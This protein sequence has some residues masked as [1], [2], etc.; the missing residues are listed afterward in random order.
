MARSQLRR[1][2]VRTM[3]SFHLYAVVLLVIF[4]HTVAADE[5]SPSEFA[6][7]VFTDLAPLLALFGEQF[8]RQFM[9]ESLTWLDHIIFAMAP[10]GI[11]TAIVGAIR[12][13]GPAWAKAFIGRA[14]ESRAAAEIEL[15]SSTSSEVCEVYNGKGVV[16]AMGTPK[17]TQFILFPPG[18]RDDDRTCGIHTLETAY[19]RKQPFLEKGEYGVKTDWETLPQQVNG[20]VIGTGI[21]SGKR[22]ALGFGADIRVHLEEES[23]NAKKSS[24]RKDKQSVLSTSPDGTM[25]PRR[26]RLWSRSKSKP[27][28][29]ED[30]VVDD[31]SRAEEKQIDEHSIDAKDTKSIHRHTFPE[32]LKGSAPNLQLNLPSYLPSHKATIGELWCA[33]VLA[34]FLQ[35]SVVVVSA[36]TSFHPRIQQTIGRPQMN[37]GFWLFIAGTLCLNLGMILCSFVIEQS[38]R[39]WAWRKTTRGLQLLG[40]EKEGD[41]SINSV[42]DSSKESQ[43]RSQVV[44]K[45]K[46]NAIAQRQQSSSKEDSNEVSRAD[47]SK[48]LPPLQLFWMQQKHTVSDQDFDPFLILGG[49]KDEILTSSRLDHEKWKTIW[50]MAIPE[51]VTRFAGNQY[52][53]LTICAS[54]FGLVGF[55]LQF[56]G[57]RGLAWPTAVSQLGAIFLLALLRA[58]IRRR[59]GESPTTISTF[60][61]HELDWLTLRLVYEQDALTAPQA[62]GDADAVKA[63]TRWKVLT[64]P[65][66]PNVCKYE[67]KKSL[68]DHPG[69]QRKHSNSHEISQFPLLMERGEMVDVQKSADLVHQRI[70][71][72]PEQD[73]KYLFQ[74]TSQVAVNVRR[75]LGELAQ[76]PGAASQEAIALAQAMSLV[77]T[78]LCP[79]QK[80]SDKIFTWSLDTVMLKVDEK[81]EARQP[82]QSKRDKSGNYQVKTPHAIPGIKPDKVTLKATGSKKGWRMRPADIDAILSL[83]MSTLARSGA[84]ANIKGRAHGKRGT[85]DDDMEDDESGNWL[86]QASSATVKYRRILGDNPPRYKPQDSARALSESDTGTGTNKRAS[87]VRTDILTRDLNWWTNDPRVTAITENTGDPQDTD[88]DML[89]IGFNGLYPRRQTVPNSD[90]PNPPKQKSQGPPTNESQVP[91]ASEISAKLEAVQDE[92]IRGKVV[93]IISDGPLAVV[94]AHHIF[95]AFMW[96]VSDEI[97]EDKIDTAAVEDAELFDGSDFQNTWNIPTLRNKRLMKLARAIVGL[98]LGPIDDVLL[99]II[100]PLSHRGILPNEAMMSVLLRKTKDHER[101]HDWPQ[102]Q[103]TYLNLLDLQMDPRGMD[104]ISYEIVVELIE[105]LF[106]ARETIDDLRGSMTLEGSEMVGNQATSLRQAVQAVSSG[107]QAHELLF[108]VASQLHW[109]YYRQRRQTEFGNLMKSLQVL[110][111]EVKITGDRDQ[112]KKVTRPDD[113]LLKLVRSSSYHEYIARRLAEKSVRSSDEPTGQGMKS[114]SKQTATMKESEWKQLATKP[115][116]FGWYPLHYATVGGNSLLFHEVSKIYKDRGKPQHELRDKSGRTPLHYAAM[117]QPGWIKTLTGTQEKGKSAAKVLGRNGMLPIH[118]AARSGVVESLANL[119]KYC[120][121]NAVD[122]FGRSALHLAVL[123]VKPEVVEFLLKDDTRNTI[124]QTGDEL[125]QR[126]PL[127]FALVSAGD[128]DD[129][130]EFVDEK[131]IVNQLMA[132]V[133][134]REKDLEAMTITDERKDT[135]IKLALRNQDVKLFEMLLS[136]L[137]NVPRPRGTDAERSVVTMCFTSM[138]KE[139]VRLKSQK[140]LELLFKH[141]KD[142]GWDAWWIVDAFL[143]A[144]D[145]SF[146]DMLHRMLKIVDSLVVE[147]KSG[148]TA[149]AGATEETGES[150]EHM[151]ESQVDT[152]PFDPKAVLTVTPKF[153]NDLEREFQIRKE[154]VMITAIQSM[155]SNFV[156]DVFDKGI[157]DPEQELVWNKQDSQKRSALAYIAKLKKIRKV[158]KGLSDEEVDIPMDKRIDMLDFLWGNWRVEDKARALNDPQGKYNKTP[159]IYAVRNNL[160][161]LAKKFVAAIVKANAQI[162]GMDRHG[163]SAFMYA[164]QKDDDAAEEWWKI[165]ADADP[166]LVNEITGTSKTTFETTPLIEAIRDGR[167]KIIEFLS[168]YPTNPDLGDR[169]G[170]PAL[171]WAY[172]QEDPDLLSTL[173]TK[174]ETIGPHERNNSGSS[175]LMYAYRDAMDDGISPRIEKMFKAPRINMQGYEA[176]LMLSH[177]NCRGNVD[178]VEFLLKNHADPCSFDD[179]GRFQVEL[180]AL[181]GNLEVFK[182]LCQTPKIAKQ[183]QELKRVYHA[184]V[185]QTHGR[186]EEIIDELIKMGIEIST[187]ELDANGWSIEDCATY[188]G[189]RSEGVK[190]FIKGGK[191]SSPRRGHITPSRWALR[192][193]NPFF[194]AHGCTLMVKEPFPDG[195]PSA[196][197]KGSQFL[198]RANSCIPYETTQYYWQME[199]VNNPADIP[200]SM[201]I[202]SPHSESHCQAGWKGSASCGYH[203]DDGSVFDNTVDKE[204]YRGPPWSTGRVVGCL[205]VL[206]GTSRTIEFFIDGSSIGPALKLPDNMRGQLYP[207]VGMR[208][209]LGSEDTEVKA[210]FGAELKPPQVASNGNVRSETAASEESTEQVSPATDSTDAEDGDRGF[211]IGRK[212]SA[213]NISGATRQ[214]ENEPT[215]QS[216]GNVGDGVDR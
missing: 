28:D 56:E 18:Y 121:L 7:T 212:P 200:I 40:P 215:A 5:D 162:E 186:N 46:T 95:S 211:S 119:E 34:V 25:G 33:A 12:V 37:F 45:T 107:L 92:A 9:S 19:D 216:E 160:L 114:E 170:D 32:E 85:E 159:L 191:G 148:H 201:G 23:D 196:G 26:R 16:R 82:N 15:M 138:L 108:R 199:I 106:L 6:F 135:P 190:L 158:G 47:V 42:K 77:L 136:K 208:A 143:E 54:V 72:Q 210:T 120:N 205:I 194:K 150:D 86:S 139:A 4:P 151:T 146:V 3:P 161:P 87:I 188:A 30:P 70:L 88:D 149:S 62:S 41:L 53:F 52:E 65:D 58:I 24:T 203:S 118:C 198:V 197:N 44:A 195:L 137:P 10:L 127:H 167:D 140:V 128:K 134:A 104:R 27:P 109:F 213:G 130:P 78:D 43:S 117:Y 90:T 91:E 189:Y 122:S 38:T 67:D 97:Q 187:T 59:L 76:C 55:I 100:P 80:D 74:Q 31:E 123:A 113:E 63:V 11:V 185:Q 182:S 142:A 35:L 84:N 71:R 141:V 155:D 14:R 36:V 51:W 180:A 129:R 115:D 103:T 177:A 57:L 132:R 75:R 172:W 2:M 64:R 105:F 214:V 181:H 173:F 126:T 29:V 96:A 154:L 61:G 125:L 98:G 50:G 171:V 204:E 89:E 99:A 13:S 21:F 68:S 39:E 111:S 110:P 1:S 175:P 133:M 176:T 184:C 164:L 124:I 206:E 183:T 209:S 131:N 178:L 94:L 207:C 193:G 8:A 69:A 73:S 144:K 116:I 152:K 102:A 145:R 101:D 169:D 165:L 81:Y 163:S 153:R 93:S 156:G 157:E 22:L 79:V 192:S 147:P 112:S 48:E 174:F 166:S 168:K 60:A 66:L 49:H 179:A 202:C 83:W 17:L 20:Q